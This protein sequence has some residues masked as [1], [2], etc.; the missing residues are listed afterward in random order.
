MKRYRGQ[1]IPIKNKSFTKKRKVYCDNII[2]F[3]IET[4]SAW[5]NDKGEIIGDTLT[6]EEKTYLDYT[7]LSMCYEWTLY[8]DGYT[9]YGRDLKECVQAFK[10][11]NDNINGI[12]FC[13]I[14]NLSW[15]FQY[16]INYFTVKEVFA[17]SPHHPI[18]V[19]FE[20][21]PN[22]EFRCSYIMTLLSLANWGKK[23]G[24]KKAVGDLDYLVQRTPKTT[25]TEQELF[26]CERDVEIVA[27]G[28]A[29]EL[30]TYKHVVDIPLT[31]TGHVRRE[32]KKEL[33][34]DRS[35]L[36]FVSKLAPK[37]V[38]DYR[39]ALKAYWGAYTHANILHVG[40]IIKN[41]YC[42]DF[43]SS[44]PYCMTVFKY[45]MTA[46][47]KCE[48]YDPDTLEDTAYL[49]HIKIENMKAKTFN[50]YLSTSKCLNTS[51]AVVD[52]GR[53][54]NADMVEIICIAEDFEIIK[55]CY[56]F[57]YE[58]IE[59]WNA[60]KYYL[61]LPLVKKVLE[62]YKNKTQYKNVIGYESIYAQSKQYINSI[63]G[64][65]CTDIIFD[66]MKY[67]DEEWITVNKTEKEVNEYLRNLHEVPNRNVF[68][69]LYWGLYV[70][71]YARRNL[72]ECILHGNDEKVIYC[73]TDSIKAVEHLDFSW[74]NNNV[75]KT[76][77]KVCKERGL[78]KADFEPCDP[79]GTP[80]L[81]G[82]F[83]EEPF[84]KEFKTW[85]AKKYCYRSSEDD[86]LHIA[87]SGVPKNASVALKNDIE[88]FTFD[89]KF[90][91]DL[92][93]VYKKELND[94]K[95]VGN[96]LTYCDDMPEVIFNKGQYD[97]YKLDVKHGIN[98]RRKSYQMGIT[99]DFEFLIMMIEEKTGCRV[100]HRKEGECFT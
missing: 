5:I 46:F 100:L 70:T 66:D 8:I 99:G 67:L 68:L 35:Y 60:N 42:Y 76:I 88:N 14:H 7:P 18:K 41:V 9:Y 39:T 19:I 26:Y 59:C 97:E 83:V 90:E 54:I 38:D 55:K 2:S 11:I 84:Y 3:D 74:Y 93:E 57:N 36:R 28:I 63:Y 56:D 10:Y 16:L 50:H 34:K 49:L 40:K 92:E 72:F 79:D 69:S 65:L 6:I 32:I 22:I 33:T 29:D 44:Y 87:I 27:H 1:P 24:L 98:L 47:T 64:M 30:K 52:N 96:Y 13:Y 43:A 77:K 31:Q 48:K 82:E 75:R 78:N 17:R 21:I 53:I 71:M 73:D 80:H 4:T 61:P 89:F 23:L 12:C 91:R 25:L 94:K 85:G 58:I 62:Y 45:P 95:A 51:K 37:T 20:E 15:E 86:K 81:L